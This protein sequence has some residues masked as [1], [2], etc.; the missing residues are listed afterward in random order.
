MRASPYDLSDL[1]FTPIPIETPEGRKA[2]EEA[3]Q[4]Y[5]AQATP[6]RQSLIKVAEQLLEYLPA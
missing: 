2:Y 5:T 4:A 3:Q 6:V 1:G